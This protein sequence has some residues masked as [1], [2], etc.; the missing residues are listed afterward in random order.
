M[1]AA[2]TNPYLRDRATAIRAWVIDV[3]MFTVSQQMFWRFALAAVGLAVRVDAGPF[4]TDAIVERLADRC[5]QP[6]A[7]FGGQAVGGSQWMQ[8]GDVQGFIGI[9]VADACHECLVKQQT[10]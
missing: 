5:I 3:A 4:V 2:Q 7:F 6:G 10:L 9:Y 8:P 1:R